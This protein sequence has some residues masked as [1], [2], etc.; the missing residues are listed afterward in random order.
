[1]SRRLLIPALALLWVASCDTGPPVSSPPDTQSAT[2][3]TPGPIDTAEADATEEPAD[4]APVGPQPIEDPPPMVVGSWNLK[5]F[6]LY[7]ANDFRLDDLAD[8]IEVLAPDVLA[9]QEI[10]VKEGTEGDPEPLEGLL[11]RRPH[12]RIT[13]AA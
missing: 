8:E 4:I 2:D 1:M 13:R 3:S 10:K 11:Q 12:S 9:L 5:N 7:G 6:S